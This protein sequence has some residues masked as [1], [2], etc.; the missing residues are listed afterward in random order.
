[1]GLL[2]LARA[3]LQALSA[4]KLR[5][6][7][8]ILGVV[9]GVAAVVAVV[10]MIEG[11]TSEVRSRIASLGV[12]TIT[13]NLFPQALRQSGLSPSFLAQEITQEFERASAVGQVVPLTQ[14]F[15]DMIFEGQ[16]WRVRFV[17]TTPQYAEIFNFLPGSGRFLHP[18]DQERLVIVLGA[19]VAQ[20]V[21]GSENPIGQDLSVVISGRTA[22]FRVIGVMQRRGRVA[23]QDLDAQAYLPINTLRKI[24]NFSFFDSYIAQARDESLV[25]AA[26]TQIEE[27]LE[28]QFANAALNARNAPQR[29]TSTPGGGSQIQVLPF[30]TPSSAARTTS[31]RLPFYRVEQQRETVAA[32]EETTRVLVLILGGIAAIALIVGGIGIMNIMLVSV[33]ERTREIGIRIAVG[34]RPRDIWG[35][36][37]GESVLICL[38]GGLIGLGLGWLSAWLGSYFGKWPFVLSGLPAAVAF[39]FSV[40]IG[41]VFGL[42]PAL[43]AARLD[44]VEALR[45]E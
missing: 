42:Y 29:I 21:F 30:T 12:R 33:T 35:Q 28:R 15:G 40:I 3:G 16:S 39:G 5:T 45:Y 26:A 38:V 34:A 18:L 22:L 41:I 1:M 24:A 36:F 11:A 25:D 9:V 20:D 7:L 31:R 27:I 37:L 10:A 19:Q 6:G 44:P 32:F 17:G 8:S 43:R 23:N 13:V 14:T 2:E 4:H